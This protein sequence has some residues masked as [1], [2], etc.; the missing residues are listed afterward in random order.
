[1]LWKGFE[2]GF[3]RFFQKKKNTVKTS[4]KYMARVWLHKVLSMVDVHILTLP[5]NC[6]CSAPMSQNS[7]LTCFLVGVIDFPYLVD[8]GLDL[9]REQGTEVTE[10][11]V[12]SQ[13]G[14][15]RSFLGKENSL[16]TN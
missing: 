11:F 16:A 2:H 7:P 15:G 14:E 1:M 9:L 6:V 3:I 5:S 4:E 13:H 10:L 12:T 8:V